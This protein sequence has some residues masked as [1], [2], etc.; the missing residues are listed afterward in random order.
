MIFRCLVDFIRELLL[1]S[2][3]FE[4]DGDYDPRLPDRSGDSTIWHR[5]TGVGVVGSVLS[6]M[7]SEYGYVADRPECGD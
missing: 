3:L 5:T 6:K 7:S 4:I 2:M 1:I